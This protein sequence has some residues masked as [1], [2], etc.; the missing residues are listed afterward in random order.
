MKTTIFVNVELYALIL[1]G[2]CDEY[3]E[4]MDAREVNLARSF[5][6]SLAGKSFHYTDEADHVHCDVT[7]KLTA[8]MELEIITEAA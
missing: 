2:T 8:C 3:Q 4:K 6:S 7:G 5:V 1:N